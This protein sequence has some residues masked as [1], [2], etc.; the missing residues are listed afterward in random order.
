M[1]RLHIH[2]SVFNLADSIQFYTTLFAT[3]PTVVKSD[4][5]KWMLDNPRLNFA[6]SERGQQTGLNHLGFQVESNAELE[7]INQRLEQAA[8]PVK[9]QLDATCCYAKS[10]KYWTIDPQGIPWEAFHTLNS[11]PTFSEPTTQGNASSSTCCA[12]SSTGCCS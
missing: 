12:P 7:E 4:Y 11:I 10:D 3:E 5:A 6:I 2:L 9:A 1:K 8:L